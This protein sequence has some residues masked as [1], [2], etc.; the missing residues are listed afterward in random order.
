[1]PEIR[2]C[3]RECGD[4]PLP[5]LL[6]LL[7]SPIHEERLF[8]LLGMVRLFEGD[9]AGRRTIYRAHFAHSCWIDNWDL[10]DLSASRSDSFAT[11][12]GATRCCSPSGSSTTLAT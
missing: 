10:V 9:E 8:A 4:V 5:V 12:S 1:M 3:A 6:Q 2:A 11:A 7:R